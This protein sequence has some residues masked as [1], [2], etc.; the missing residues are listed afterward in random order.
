MAPPLP[1]AAPLAHEPATRTI[2][3]GNPVGTQPLVSYSYLP[4]TDSRVASPSGHFSFC[5]KALGLRSVV[6]LFV[7]SSLFPLINKVVQ[8]DVLNFQIFHAF[9]MAFTYPPS[10]L[11]NYK[12]DWW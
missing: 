2:G 3:A 10:H 7:G 1:T 12:S 9:E 8:Q 6:P 11:A 5:R 4:V